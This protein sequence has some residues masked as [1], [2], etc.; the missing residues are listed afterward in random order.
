M[1]SLI[2]FLAF[3]DPGVRAV[4]LGAMLLG[5]GAAVVGCFTFLRK[6]ALVGDAVA[7][8]VLPGVCLA[9]ILVDVVGSLGWTD[10]SPKHP[11]ALIAGAFVSSWISLRL[12]DFISFKSRIKEDT[13]IGLVLSVFFGIGILLLTLIQ[14]G[15]SAEK[16]G[17]DSILFGRIAALTAGDVLL[18]GAVAT[19]LV[20]ITL[21]LYKEFQLM[22]FDE[23]FA[24]VTGLP[25][26]RLELT[27]T[28]LTVLAVIVAIQAVGVVM[29]AA[30]LITPPAAAR[31]WTERLPVMIFLAALFGALAGLT[32]AYA[33]FTA[34]RAPTGPWIVIVLTGFAI[35]SVLFA[36]RRGALA[37]QLR[38]R[39]NA[40]RIRH[41]NILKALFHLGE[42]DD[43]F[44]AARSSDD[45]LARRPMASSVLR[46]GLEQLRRHGY[47]RRDNATWA[48]TAEGRMR[49]ARITRLHRLWEVYLTQY[50]GIAPDHVHDDAETIEHILTPEL[51]Q[52]LEALLDHPQIDPH[53]RAIPHKHG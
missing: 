29:T 41:E 15:S 5:I 10:L 30:I 20:F 6:R 18:F 7:H 3:D 24:A 27:L 53:A 45:I 40:G 46:R 38:Q 44:Y 28:T 14:H 12:I 2:E 33:S 49:G 17:L 8:A 48:L 51:E 21:M 52:E 1:N 50:V 37:R 22:S 19:V 9:F 39:R 35:L 32:G 47:V 11:L 13:A 4:S 34:P 42:Q 16:A 26:R 31:Y 36:P 23:E 43:D 25:V